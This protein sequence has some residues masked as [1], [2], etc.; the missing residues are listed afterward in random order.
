MSNVEENLTIVQE[1]L[2]NLRALGIEDSFDLEMDIMNNM[3]DFYEKFP[4][5]VK[6]LCREAN[7]DNTYLYKMINLLKEVE[8]GNKSL[9]LIELELGNE[10]AEK[11]VYP[12]I[13][14][15]DKTK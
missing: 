10:L 6:R 5:L 11:F 15:L 4:A 14:K 13:E 2:K 1:K 8:T 7:Q 9:S 3:P 12:V